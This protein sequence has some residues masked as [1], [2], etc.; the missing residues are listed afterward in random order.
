MLFPKAW[1]L[2]AAQSPFRQD[3]RREQKGFGSRYHTARASGPRKPLIWPLMATPPF[4]GV[5]R[6]TCMHAYLKSQL[7]PLLERQSTHISE[8]KILRG[9]AG[10][11][12][13]ALARADTTTRSHDVVTRAEMVIWAETA[14]EIS[15]HE[16]AM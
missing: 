11:E 15:I 3:G 13:T 9:I 2:Y 1:V 6:L 14:D 8:L 16:L 4:N 10:E 12:G 5:P 7:I